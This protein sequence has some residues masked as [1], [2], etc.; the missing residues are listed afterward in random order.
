MKF[1][2]CVVFKG[3]HSMVETGSAAINALM[4]ILLLFLGS[5]GRLTTVARTIMT[6]SPLVGAW[7]KRMEASPDVQKVSAGQGL[8][9]AEVERSK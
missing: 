3:L 6:R 4:R 8:A 9:I 2:A 5:I 7:Y 1:I